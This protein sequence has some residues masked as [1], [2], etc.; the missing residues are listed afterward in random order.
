M[1]QGDSPILADEMKMPRFG[2]L[3]KYATSEAQMQWFDLPE[4]TCFHYVNA[5]EE[6]D[7]IL[8]VGSA[9]MPLSYVFEQPHNLANRLSLFRLNRKSGKAYKE[10]LSNANL[11]VG[12]F[13]QQYCGRKNR[14]FYMSIAG[15]WPKYSGI[16][17]VDLEA[18]RGDETSDRASRFGDRSIVG[19]RKYP[20]GC[21]GS[22]PAF[23]P[24][25]PGMD[26]IAEDDG[27]LITHYHDENTGISELL[28]LDA[29]SPTLETVACI[30]IPSRVP[31]GFHGIFLTQEQLS[32][33]K[34]LLV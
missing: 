6:G 8:V 17:K 7:E 16:A 11:D 31:Y 10:Q 27:Y 3:P 29:L 19:W 15:P 30:K 5:W 34:R 33:Q 21:F 9:S 4:S 12:T 18:F 32:S 28:I 25:R 23:V 26:S 2:V 24:R 1:L 14:F 20:P 13:N 22:E